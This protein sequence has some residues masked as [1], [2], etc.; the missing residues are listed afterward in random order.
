MS[1]MA[2]AYK[3]PRF[4]V[5]EYDRMVDAGIFD[6]HPRVELVH[7]ELIEPMAPMNLPHQRVII[8]LTGLIAPR[9]SGRADVSVQ[10]P[11]RL[12]GNSEPEPDL[13]ILKPEWVQTNKKPGPQDIFWLIETAHSSRDF[14]RNVKM[15]LYASV[16]ISEA[17]LIDLIDDVIVVYRDPRP[18]G[19]ATTLTFTRGQT[20]APLAFP[21]EHLPVSEMLPPR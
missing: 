16:G 17:W 10:T 11:I 3:T 2:I 14:D 9:L 7:G 12:N 15:P 1:E 8:M 20:I 19:Y 5:E 18:D 6:M 21:D 13:A 4:T